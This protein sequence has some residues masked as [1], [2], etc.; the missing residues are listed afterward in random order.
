MKIYDMRLF[1]VAL[2]GVTVLATP[3]AASIC[4]DSEPDAGEQCDDGNLANGDGCD[5]TCQIEPG[6]ECSAAIPGMPPT[7]PVPSVCTVIGAT[8]LLVRESTFNPLYSYGGGAFPYV[9]SLLDAAASVT[10]VA[11]FNDASQVSSADALWIDV[12]PAFSSGGN[13]LSASE[14]TNISDFIASGRRVVMIG[15]NASFTEW[16]NSILG[17]VG[18]TFFGFANSAGSL[19]VIADT[20]ITA[21]FTTLDYNPQNSGVANPAPNATQLFDQNFAALW[22]TSQNVLI[23]LDSNVFISGTFLGG[24]RGRFLRN[25]AGWVTESRVAVPDSLTKEIISGPDV[26]GM[27]GVD[28]VVEVGQLISTEYDFKV[29]YT[30]LDG[31]PVLIEDTVPAEWNAQLMDDDGS[32]ASVDSANKKGKGKGATKIDWE[33]E[34]V[35]GMITVSADTRQKRRNGKFSPT[36]CGALYL[37]DGAQA[38][39]IDAVTLEPKVDEFGERLPPILESNQLC[40]AA[41]SD[42]N[43]GGIVRDGSGDED[44]DGLTD[45]AEACEVGTDPCVDDTDGDGVL[46]GADACPLEAAVIDI[47]GDGCE[48]PPAQCGNGTL[49]APEQCDDGNTVGGDGCSDTCQTEVSECVAGGGF[50]NVDTCEGGDQDGS[51]CVL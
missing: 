29:S 30:N 7:P 37:N 23:V 14:I 44:A 20:P 21:G 36:A 31:P 16:N 50:C 40:L 39:E 43:G 32:R 6:F 15:E 17:I 46:D 49:E 41:V 51:A 1:L 12:G 27:N 48:D 3:A 45:L 10:E 8:N 4:G 13:D 38:F 25:I 18:G 35:G 24:T 47:G 2:A 42:L 22:G 33:P 19:S 11:D 34:P 9:T 28:V 26:D 5:D